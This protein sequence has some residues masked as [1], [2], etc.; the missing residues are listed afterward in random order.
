MELKDKLISSYVAFENGLNVDSDIHEIRTKAL[1][2]FEKLGFPTKKLEAWKYTSLNSVLKEDYSIFPKGERTVDLAD[3]KKYFIHDIDTYKIVF[4]DGKYSS[5]LSETTHENIDV[6]LLSSALEKSKYK[7]VIENYFNK[8]AKQDN[9]TS[10]NTAFATEGAYI[11]I[12]R[13]VEVDKPIQIIYFTTGAENATMLQPRNLVVAERN[14]HVQII[15]RHQSLTDNPVLTNSVTEIFGDV[16]SNVDFYKIQNDNIK[17]TLV[18]NTYIEQQS[19]SVCSVHTFSFGGNITRNNLNF[20]QKGEHIDSIQKGITILEGKQ[21]V[22]HHTLVHHIEPNCE[23]HQDYK[24]I[25][26][27][28]STGV[29]NG[30]VIVEKEAQ[31]TNAYQQNNNVLVSDKATVNAKPQLEIFADDVKCSHG[32]TIGQ[33]DDQ[34]L[35]YMQQRGIPKKQAKALLMY[36][37]SNTV[38]ES[39]RIPEVKQRITKI[40]AQ[41]LGVDIGFDL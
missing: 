32:C 28:R 11:H 34:A 6:C 33:L 7:P 26:T 30:K 3:V 39:V 9:L 37:F 23:S 4:I 27:D 16:H 10:L 2:N 25:Y 19:D 31:K 38:L 36:A 17:A 22:D 13:N 1:Q 24:G 12:P 21:H 18:D 15:E 29:F 40:I 20:Y 8:V 14:A 5:F 35:F 41:K